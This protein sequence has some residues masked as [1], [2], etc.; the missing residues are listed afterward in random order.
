MKVEVADYLL[1]CASSDYWPEGI[2][3][4]PEGDG[5]P[6]S[7][8]GV[9]EHWNNATE[10]QYSRNLGTGNG[11]ELNYVNVATIGVQEKVSQEIQIAAPNPFS[12]ST[13][14]I[15]PEHLSKESSLEIYNIRGE[16]VQ[17]FDFSS[18]DKISWDGSNLKGNEV[19][20]GIYIYSIV[21]TKKQ[22]VLG[23]KVVLNR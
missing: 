11:I 4:D 14:F 22:S 7:S 13:Q 1:Q 16:L 9:F 20:N 5:T 21:D 3:Y 17:Q 15:R 23:G 6:I 2:K 19:P 8:L 18:S 12:I 10:R